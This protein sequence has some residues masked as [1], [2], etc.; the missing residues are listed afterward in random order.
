MNSFSVAFFTGMFKLEKLGHVV[1]LPS[2]SAV[3]HDSKYPKVQSR[4]LLP[5]DV[6]REYLFGDFFVVEIFGSN[7][8]T[9]SVPEAGESVSQDIPMLV[10]GPKKG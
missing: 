4:C 10:G 2:Q 7:V 3:K 9:H 1:W 5:R 8:P 6:D